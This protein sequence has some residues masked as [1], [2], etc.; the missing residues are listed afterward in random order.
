MRP[1]TPALALVALLSMGCH[2]SARGQCE[3][4]TRSI[5]QAIAGKPSGLDALPFQIRV[6]ATATALE[7]MAA[8]LELVHTTD[9][10][11]AEQVT[12]LV[13]ACRTRG[14]EVRAIVP[15]PDAAPDP[16]GDVRRL[17]EF[18]G[19]MSTWNGEFLGAAGRADGY[20]H[21]AR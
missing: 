17:G 20:C 21:A 3:A 10:Y 6:T 12:A 4:F 7:G 18:L 8:R 5:G 14:A 16:L 1:R 2:R 9:P 19:T 11:L 15:A 13:A